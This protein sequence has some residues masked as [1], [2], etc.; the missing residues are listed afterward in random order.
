MREKRGLAFRYLTRYLPATGAGVRPSPVHR[1]DV[2][3]VVLRPE[4]FPV[5]EKRYTDLVYNVFGMSL[6]IFAVLVIEFGA[7]DPVH[8]RPRA[9]D[10]LLN[11]KELIV[12]FHKQGPPDP[13]T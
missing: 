5:E 12:V 11:V 10:E 13:F 8:L 2:H 4:C 1:E 9:H 7:G 6:R 3:R